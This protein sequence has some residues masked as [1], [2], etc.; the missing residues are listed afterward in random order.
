MIK[1]KPIQLAPLGR[2][3][4]QCQEDLQASWWAEWY[5]FERDF[6]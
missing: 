2:R 1:R 4:N 6:I 3:I 5:E